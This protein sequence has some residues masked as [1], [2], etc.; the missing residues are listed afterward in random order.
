MQYHFAVVLCWKS[1][2]GDLGYCFVSAEQWDLDQQREK[3]EGGQ[4][5]EIFFFLF[6]FFFLLLG[7]NWSDD[8]GAGAYSYYNL[9]TVAP[10]PILSFK[11]KIVC[12]QTTYEEDTK[13]LPK[14]PSKGLTSWRDW[15]ARYDRCTSWR[16][17]V[18]TLVTPHIHAQVS[19]NI[20]SLPPPPFSSLLLSSL[21]LFLR[22]SS[23]V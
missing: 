9:G 10:D 17:N 22:D 19:H 21:L 4:F 14:T 3:G 7:E 16:P 5:G 15:D 8:K 12:N 18:I 13:R 23:P 6:L 2:G 1:L 20:T 11:E